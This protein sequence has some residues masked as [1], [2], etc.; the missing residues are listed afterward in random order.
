MGLNTKCPIHGG[1]HPDFMC[2]DL[3]IDEE[4]LDLVEALNIGGIPTIS[5]CSGHDK[6][7]GHIWL[8]DN[9]VLIVLPRGKSKDEI[10]SILQY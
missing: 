2:P 10:E 4:I 8:K 5:S 6:E 3:K 9:R 1:D 7:Y